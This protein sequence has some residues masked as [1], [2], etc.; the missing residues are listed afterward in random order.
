MP[1][2]DFTRKKDSLMHILKIKNR[3]NY[4]TLTNSTIKYNTK[5]QLL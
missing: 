1:D 4:Y 3:K 2:F 5:S